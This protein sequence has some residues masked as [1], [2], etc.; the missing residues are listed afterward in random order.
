MVAA[1]DASNQPLFSKWVSPTDWPYTLAYVVGE[2]R[3]ILSYHSNLTEEQRPPKSIW[4]S[5]KKCADW[6]DEHMPGRESAGGNITFNP[7]EIER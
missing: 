4:H 3:R 7:N 1:A 2:A 5:R 6:I